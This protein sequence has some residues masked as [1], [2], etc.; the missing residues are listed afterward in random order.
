MRSPRGRCGGP[1]TAGERRTLAP[2]LRQ[3]LRSV[4]FA[5]ALPP[6]VALLGT[7]HSATDACSRR[8]DYG[9][10]EA[11]VNTTSIARGFAIP[12]PGVG[13][14]VDMDKVAVSY[15]PGD[16]S[17]ARVFGQVKD[18][19]LCQRDAFLS[20]E[21]GITLCP[22]ACDEVRADLH[23]AV[24]VLFTCESTVIVR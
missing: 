6:T 1:A 8:D 16:G 18:P 20:S 21:D 24:D 19:A 3:R 9:L 4:C 12:T 15:A 10:A 23:A 2:D 14:T 22:A 11:V 5:L 13:R 7:H 17:A